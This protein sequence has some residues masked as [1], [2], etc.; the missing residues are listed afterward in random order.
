MR[1][2]TAIEFDGEVITK[3]SELQ[4]EI[5]SDGVSGN[6]TNP[7]NLH[8]TLKFLGEVEP[9]GINRLKSALE[10]AAEK[11]L[12]FEIAA[13]NC[14][15]FTSR[16]EKT[17]W[18]GMSGDG[19][20]QLAENVDSR[21]AQIGFERENRKFTPHVTLVRRADFDSAFIS[22]LDVRDIK[23]RVDFA[24][25]FESRRDAGKLLYKPLFRANLKGKTK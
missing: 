19:L 13:D 11:S 6:F 25:L 14:G 18:L 9:S 24:T 2:F 22:R 23:F 5:R 3:I 4:K 17:V 8:L 16:G 20:S 21:F 1:I 10:N 7:E 12:P 15:F